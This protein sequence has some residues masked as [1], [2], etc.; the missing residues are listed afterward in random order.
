[1]RKKLELVAGP[2]TAEKTQNTAS[3]CDENC[4]PEVIKSLKEKY[5]VSSRSEQIRILTIFARNM[6][7]RGMMSEFSCSQRMAVQAKNLEKEN[8]MLSSPNPKQGKILPDEVKSTVTEFYRSDEVSRI[9]PGKKDCVVV[10]NEHGKDKI[11]KRLVLNNLKELFQKFKE[12]NPGLKVGF[13]KFA[14]LRPS[15]CVLAGSGGTHSVCVCTIHQNV[16]LMMFGSK[17]PQI[18]ELPSYH[19]IARIVCN[20]AQPACYFR[21]CESCPSIEDFKTELLSAY[22][23]EDIDEIQF[24]RWTSTDRSELSSMVLPLEEFINQFCERAVKLV[25]HDFIAKAQSQFLKNKKDEIGEGEFVIIGDFSENYSFVVQDA[26]QGFHW[27]CSQATI[28]P[29]VYYFKSDDGKLNHDSFTIISECNTHDVVS[30]HLFQRMLIEHLK[31]SFGNVKQLYY[32]SGGC[33]GQYKNCKAFINLCRHKSEYGID[34]EW[35]FFATSH[36]KG[37]SDGVGGTVKREATRESL[38]RP[39]DSQIISPK[40]IFAF[41][42]NGLNEMK[43]GYG[44]QEAYDEEERNLEERLKTAKTIAG[45]QK[46]HAFIPISETALQVREFSLSEEHRIE[47]AI[48]KST[49]TFN[50]K[51][52][53]YVTVHY[54]GKWWL[55][56]IMEAF[57]DTHEVKVNFLHPNGPANSF[58]FPDIEDHCIL[59]LSDILLSVEPKTATGRTYT[60]SKKE[61]QLSNKTLVGKKS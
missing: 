50:G 35:H 54:D 61:T 17:M 4:M 49:P 31:S 28:H 44:T 32:F 24:K 2:S 7:I 16:K 47:S 59:D 33:A 15:E 45:T 48:S 21:T 26:A 1:M 34:A 14:M 57:Q 37:P 11:Q 43:F 27:N 51:L 58:F 5:V 40:D 39:Y 19:V 10:R 20:P 29:W 25:R 53:G 52:S 55:A 23:L 6:S 60:I 18:A 46:L 41:A 12:K 13:A 9:M 38:R 3:K 36:G 22:E 30:V 56:C 8:G 42:E